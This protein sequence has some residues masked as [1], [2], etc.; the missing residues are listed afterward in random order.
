MC[1]GDITT[2]L[3][4]DKGDLNSIQISESISGSVPSW[5]PAGV[6]GTV[7]CS[8]IYISKSI[9]TKDRNNECVDLTYMFVGTGSANA[10]EKPRLKLQTDDGE[11]F[12]VTDNQ[13][14][15]VYQGGS[16][17]NNSY[18]PAQYISKGDKLVSWQNDIYQYVTV[19]SKSGYCD[20]FSSMSIN[21]KNNNSVAVSA[22]MFLHAKTTNYPFSVSRL[23]NMAP[24]STFSQS[25]NGSIVPG[26]IGG[27]HP[28]VL[29]YNTTLS[30][31]LAHNFAEAVNAGHS[32]TLTAEVSNIQTGEVTIYQTIISGNTTDQPNLI[33]TNTAFNTGYL[34]SNAPTTFT[35]GKG[36]YNNA[37]CNSETAVDWMTGGTNSYQLRNG[38][39][40]RGFTGAD[41]CDCEPSASIKEY[42]CESTTS[43]CVPSMSA[44]GH[45]E[46]IEIRLS[47]SDSGGTNKTW[48]V[49][50]SGGEEIVTSDFI[51][52]QYT[53]SANYGTTESHGFTFTLGDFED[54]SNYTA[55]LLRDISWM[56]ESASNWGNDRLGPSNQMTGLLF[57]TDYG[58]PSINYSPAFVEASGTIPGP[59]LTTATAT[60]WAWIGVTASAPS[61][62]KYEMSFQAYGRIESTITAQ[63]GGT[64]TDTAKNLVVAIN[65][66]TT[67]PTHS[68]W[69]GQVTASSDGTL[70]RIMATVPGTAPNT[71]WSAQPIDYGRPSFWGNTTAVQFPNS[72]SNFDPL[73]NQAYI[74]VSSVGTSQLFMVSG[75]QPPAPIGF[76]MSYDRTDPLPVEVDVCYKESL[77]LGGSIGTVESECCTFFQF[78]KQP[79]T[80]SNLSTG[81][82]CQP[83]MGRN[84]PLTT[85]GVHNYNS[86][87]YS[88]SG[89]QEGSFHFGFNNP[90]LDGDIFE[91]N[92][93]TY[94]MGVFPINFTASVS[95]SRCLNSA[96]A[97]P[98][99]SAPFGPLVESTPNFPK[100]EPDSTPCC[101]SISGSINLVA[102]PGITAGNNT[103]QCWPTMSLQ[104]GGPIYNFPELGEVTWSIAGATLNNGVVLGDYNHGQSSSV[105]PHELIY[106]GKS[107]VTDSHSMSTE[108]YLLDKNYC[109]MYT[110]SIAV[111]HSGCSFT[112]T[113]FIKMVSASTAIA[114]A[115]TVSFCN[116]EDTESFQEGFPVLQAAYIGNGVGTW[117]HVIPSQPS[118]APGNPIILSPSKFRT[119]V[120][121][122]LN[123]ACTYRWTEFS[124][125]THVIGEDTFSVDCYD[126][127]DVMLQYE[128]DP[129]DVMFLGAPYFA[130][131]PCGCPPQAIGGSQ[132]PAM[133]SSSFNLQL[134][135]TFQTFI[136]ISVHENDRWGFTPRA[137]GLRFKSGF[138]ASWQGAIQIPGIKLIASNSGHPH[139]LG[140]DTSVSS[141]GVHSGSKERWMLGAHPNL[142]TLNVNYANF[143]S[144]TWWFSSSLSASHF[145]PISVSAGVGG[146]FGACNQG[147]DEH[148]L[149]TVTPIPPTNWQTIQ[150]WEP[151]IGLNLADDEGA[152][153]RAIDPSTGRRVM[154]FQN[155]AAISFQTQSGVN[156]VQPATTEST[157][158]ISGSE[159]MAHPQICGAPFLTGSYDHCPTYFMQD[160]VGTGYTQVFNGGATSWQTAEQDTNPSNNSHISNSVARPNNLYA[161]Y[162]VWPVGSDNSDSPVEFAPGTQLTVPQ[163]PMLAFHGMSNPEHGFGL[164][165]RWKATPFAHY[166]GTS[167]VSEVMTAS[168][169]EGSQWPGVYTGSFADTM[170]GESFVENPTYFPSLNKDL[171]NKVQYDGW[172]GSW[173]APMLNSAGG[174]AGKVYEVA[175]VQSQSVFFEVTASSDCC[176]GKEYYA[177]MSIMFTNR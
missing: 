99:F 106:F 67:H 158:L 28:Q 126:S 163:P 119:A 76:T 83:N 170:T 24:F 47:G 92:D 62:W 174:S 134:P 8:L 74:N 71:R 164:K 40:L 75:T 85:L 51:N 172:T 139:G 128:E 125:S 175:D 54:A 11:S 42:P 159:Q 118:S 135:G 166:Y 21:F 173:Y 115:P 4:T 9:Q 123:T 55:S 30:G 101:K 142:T 34:T 58:L 117:T 68:A 114:G 169:F 138:S 3:S 20:S 151:G 111:S 56:H 146:Q 145:H 167:G 109:G 113:V 19:V 160:Q 17:S 116:T 152:S 37:Y 70:L 2:I 16:T 15:L 93:T 31:S 59:D 161:A 60:P 132:G 57:D 154:I 105:F 69:F 95:N 86:I 103:V 26:V 53:D 48:T 121:Q 89:S 97:Q 127:A 110:M 136:S 137:R 38:I 44:H 91:P 176:P 72:E 35:G 43:F 63:I 133:I 27:P 14:I 6:T 66:A 131:G 13:Q 107:N 88:L 96:S 171:V 77:E 108:M 153:S 84:I 78:N 162:P 94:Q 144:S 5:R 129:G 50:F 148:V 65:D 100:H 49:N 32:G 140:Q 143:T 61:T 102:N 98:S 73:T 81:Y 150:F 168:A 80:S 39:V 7:S 41:V 87:I 46:S 141:T 157:I 122:D 18:I 82:V 130:G 10:P 124:T 33:S 52:T 90:E 147:D 23:Y 1:I 112:D 177:S 155:V 29:V 25:L 12:L 165:F 104:A 64:A 79:Y 22:S 45:S 36:H 120:R 156:G 149:T